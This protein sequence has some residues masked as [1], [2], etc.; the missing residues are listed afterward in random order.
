M[1]GMLKPF[2]LPPGSLI[3][4]FLALA[5]LLR[6]RGGAC[7]ALALSAAALLYALSTPYLAAWLMFSLH[8]YPPLLPQAAPPAE[9]IIVLAAGRERGQPGLGGDAA[10]ALT[11]ERLRFA[12]RLHRATGLPLLVSGGPPAGMAPM[13]ALMG[14]ALA[15]DFQV[16]ARW[17]EAASLNTAENALFSARLLEGEGLRRVLLVTHGWHLPRAMMA[18]GATG[19]DPIPAAATHVARPRLA[20]EALLPSARALSDTAYAVH[21]WLGMAQY[22]VVH[23][24]R[25]VRP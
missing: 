21:E 4:G 25:A 2:L 11:L 1:A 13:A 16:A 7:R 24:F 15:Q 22:A 8:W 9:A 6:R 10:D 17:R 18:F 3:L 19:L 20:P 5:V 23:G 14:Q 12:A